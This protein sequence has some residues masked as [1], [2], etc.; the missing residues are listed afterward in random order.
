MRRRHTAVTVLLVGASVILAVPTSSA[1]TSSAAASAPSPLTSNLI[2]GFSTQARE[3]STCANPFETTT[4]TIGKKKKAKK[5]ELICWHNRTNPDVWQWT[6]RTAATPTQFVIPSSVTWRR[7][8]TPSPGGNPQFLP[9]ANSNIARLASELDY[10]WIEIDGAA[11]KKIIAGVWA[12]KGA[13]NRPVI[14]YF[15]GTG[16]LVYW[17]TEIAANLAKNGYVVV[18]PLWYGPRSNFFDI[19]P[20]A[21]MPGLIQDP[22]GSPFTGA[23]L[24]LL[25]E[26]LPVLAA[27]KQQPGVNPASLNVAGGSRGGTIA[28]LLGATTAGIKSVI[29]VVPPFLPTQLN[30]PMYRGQV[31]EILPRSIVNRMTTPTLVL[32]AAGDEL[33]PPA[34][35]QDFLSAASAAGRTNIESTSVPGPH[36]MSFSFNADSS[37]RVRQLMLGF[38]SRFA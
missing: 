30:S 5:V 22:N 14:V 13:A 35:T 1:T 32:A 29:G 24:E 17:E 7:I 19:F 25:Q 3:G 34:S 20:A 10:Y 6:S 15:H 11:G 4:L 31:W 27:A 18:T 38:L 26:L 16:G 37:A 21:Q 12:P 9:T 33:V 2:S 28:L 36:S 8:A 23:N